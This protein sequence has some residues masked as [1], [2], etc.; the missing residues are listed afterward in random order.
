[1][2]DLLTPE[3]KEKLVAEYPLLDFSFE[4][5]YPA[6]VRLLLE[7]Q[8][9]KVRDNRPTEE[10]IREEERGKRQRSDF[11]W[12]QQIEGAVKA[13]RA[14]VLGVIVQAAQYTAGTMTI[15]ADVWDNLRE[16][17]REELR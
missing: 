10:E 2:M 13:E 11:I 4:D 1:M 3:D 6:E 16:S 9:Q 8:L 5:D 17:L 14:Y 15:P 12:A 7:T